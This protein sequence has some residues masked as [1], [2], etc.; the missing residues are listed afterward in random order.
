[1]DSTYIFSLLENVIEASDH[2]KFRM[3][4]AIVLRNKIISFGYNRMKTHPLQA[5]Y[6]SNSESIYLHAEISAIKNALK[7][8]SVSELKKC[9]MY[10]FRQRKMN[11]RYEHALAKPCSGC[12]RAIVEFGI[13]NVIYTKNE[14]HNGSSN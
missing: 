7:V 4:A 14:E 11:G 2:P 6:G 5:K 10:V 8:I 13:K 3:A 1:M 12:M 9:D